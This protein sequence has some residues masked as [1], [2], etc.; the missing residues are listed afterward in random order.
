MATE[1][2]ENL[3]VSPVG[4]YLRDLHAQY[5]GPQEGEVATYIPELGKAD[6]EWFGICL[7][8]TDGH[9]YEVGD[10]RQ[11]FSIQSISKPFVYG[12]ALEDNGLAT[13]LE[14]VGVEPTGDAFNAISLD[15]VSGIPAN[16]MINAGAIA[17]T[18]MVEGKTARQKIHRILD[19]FSRYVGR[20]VSID[21]AIYLSEKETGHRNRAISHMLRN[22]S[23]IPEDPEPV[24]DAYF[25]QCSISVTCRDLAIMAGT[26]A[27]GGVNPITGSRAVVADYVPAILSVM[28]S[29]GMYDS[30]GEW[31][32]NVGMPAK[33]GVSGGILAVLPGRLGIGVFSPPLDAVG[34]SVRGIKVC[35]DL[36][37]DMQLHLF[38]VPGA[39]LAAVRRSFDAAQ[40]SSKRLRSWHE[41][42]ILIEHGSRIKVYEL[43]GELMFA[44][45]EAVLR[46]IVGAQG[47]TDFTI[48]DLSRV[49][50]IE[51]SSCWLLARLFESLTE[52][53]KHLIF[54]HLSGKTVLVKVIRKR[55]GTA[56]AHLFVT[57]EDNDLALEWCEHR[58]IESI[59][60]RRPSALRVSP[61]EFDLFQ[62][63]SEAQLQK[64]EKLL[65]T[66][67]Y[68][69][70]EI[71]VKH[72]D[73]SSEIFFLARGKAGIALNLP[74][75]GSKRVATFSPGM[76]FGE[77][78][79]IDGSVRSGTVTADQAVEC[80][81]LAAKDFEELSNTDPEL[82]ILLLLNV[83]R[84][85]SGRLRK[86][87]AEISVLSG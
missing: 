41:R 47:K 18:G 23:I 45:T 48:I 83:T 6:S 19:S 55:L 26:L 64:I 78:G 2:P 34:N 11:A 16:P 57:F 36:S 73:S 35:R 74:T 60:E 33:S 28:G 59:A 81:V 53:N 7:V 87:N 13:V 9:V 69:D 39:H 70:G 5:S 56:R 86:S 4:E 38:K 71:I 72:G 37:R 62:N 32:Y 22:F 24:L 58:L 79:V 66:R 80:Y 76:A 42:R 61:A 44:A 25:Q 68:Q 14:K 77:M 27:N 54:T 63:F 84:G 3:C 82:K 65:T 30:A 10:S 12:I 75:G 40:V 29:C 20:C 46:E 17:S 21:R 50:R 49:Q 52:L 67:S 15:P 51:N 8:T 43:Q 31:I 1:A 85:L